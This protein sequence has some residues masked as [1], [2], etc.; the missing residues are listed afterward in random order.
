M[1]NKRIENE[2]ARTA[3]LCDMAHA[4]AEVHYAAQE[5]FQRLHSQGYD[6]F[7]ITVGLIE[8]AARSHYATGAPEAQFH[9]IAKIA[10]SRGLN[11][12]TNALLDRARQDQAWH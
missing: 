1:S 4:V 7:C 2:E 6:N 11:V 5:L 9:D 3:E 8:L 10:Y 12:E